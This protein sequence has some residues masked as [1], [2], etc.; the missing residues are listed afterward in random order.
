[1]HHLDPHFVCHFIIAIQFLLS[2]SFPLAIPFVSRLQF[3]CHLLPVHKYRIVGNACSCKIDSI[4]YDQ[5]A[6]IPPLA[7]KKTVRE[8]TLVAIES[9]KS[10]VK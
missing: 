2:S 7:R 9:A 1:M 3:I 5:A 10:N 6:N 8:S 4:K